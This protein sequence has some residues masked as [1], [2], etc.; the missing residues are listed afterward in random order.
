[1]NLSAPFARIQKTGQPWI[2]WLRGQ[3]WRVLLT[4][5]LVT[6]AISAPIYYRRIAI[7]VD[8]DY[9]S[10]V[11]FAQRISAGQAVDPLTLSH[12]LLQLILIAMHTLSGGLLGFYAA[13]MVLQVAVQVWLALILYFWMGQGERKAWD[14]LRAGAAVSLTLVAPVMLLAFNDQLLYYGYIGLANYH[15]PTIHLLK[16]VALL[17]LIYGIQALDGKM[18]GW[19]SIALAAFWLSVSTWVKPNYALAILPG[20]ALAAG[21]RLIQRRRVDW[22]MLGLGFVLPGVAMLFA[23]WLIAYYYGDPGEAIILAPFVVESSYSGWLLPKFL[24]SCLFPLVVFSDR[25][26]QPDQAFRTA[27][28]VGWPAGRRAAILPAGGRRKADI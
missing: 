11:V 22:R 25:Q 17:S 8:T 7:P 14:W 9:G 1:M 15:N 21:I 27:A 16:P 2:A 23:Q 13:L 10:H 24:L 28:G 3:N 18:S 5:V 26:A 12:P 4:L 19:G 20:L 6:A